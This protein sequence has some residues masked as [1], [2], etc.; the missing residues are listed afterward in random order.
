MKSC[1]LTTTARGKTPPGIDLLTGSPS[2]VSDLRIR[3]SVR[4]SFLPDYGS[5]GRGLE[6]LP[7]RWQ[8]ERASAPLCVGPQEAT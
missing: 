6:S 4:R 5:E 3:W 1:R 8:H 7:A 2:L